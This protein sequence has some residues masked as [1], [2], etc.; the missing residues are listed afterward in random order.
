MES[1]THKSGHRY[2]TS[3]DLRRDPGLHKELERS[4]FAWSV[5]SRTIRKER[6][7]RWL[8]RSPGLQALVLELQH[9][10]GARKAKLMTI[11]PQNFRSRKSKVLRPVLGSAAGLRATIPNPKTRL[12][13][14]S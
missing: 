10:S 14:A 3:E 4:L 7:H 9:V 5:L 6:E 13:R 1:Y 12:C 11:L 2:H 8:G